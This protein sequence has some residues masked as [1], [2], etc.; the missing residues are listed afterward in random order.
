MSLFEKKV[1]SVSGVFFSQQLGINGVGW[2]VRATWSDV[3]ISEMLGFSDKHRRHFLFD[4]CFLANISR[5]SS[6]PSRFI[7]PGAVLFSRRHKCCVI[8]SMRK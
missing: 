2:T 3:V 5:R 1:C 4:L 8:D 6:S 7:S